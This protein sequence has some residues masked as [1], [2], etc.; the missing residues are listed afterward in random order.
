MSGEETQIFGAIQK[1]GFK[2]HSFILPGTH[3]KWAVVEE[4]RIVWFSTFMTGELFA[5]LCNH[6][7][8]GRLMEKGENEQMPLF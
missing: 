1:E 3:S 8:L 4:G 6:S 5:V 2:Q 7:I